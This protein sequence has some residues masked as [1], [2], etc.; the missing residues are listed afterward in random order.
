MLFFKFHINGLKI[1]LHFVRTEIFIIYLF[2]ITYD[3]L[4]FI[5]KKIIGT[6]ILLKIILKSI[7]FIKFNF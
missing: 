1:T 2:P 4:Y 7:Y 3:Y 5:R 6:Q